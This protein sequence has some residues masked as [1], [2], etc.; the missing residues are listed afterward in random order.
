VTPSP[1]VVV[2]AAAVVLLY[3]VTS[4]VLAINLAS[5]YGT[6]NE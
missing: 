4:I 5:L 1:V 2:I 3:I 6:P